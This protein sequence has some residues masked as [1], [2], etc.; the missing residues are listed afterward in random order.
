MD[1]ALDEKRRRARYIVGDI[2]LLIVSGLILLF[3]SADFS[4]AGANATNGEHKFYVAI[5][6][7]II[8]LTLLIL[9]STY[10]LKRGKYLVSLFFAGLP[11]FLIF[12]FSILSVLG[13]GF[14][15]LFFRV[16]H[17]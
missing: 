14:G 2:V 12:I 15:L 7:S 16:H 1:V 10:Y 8:F 17:G 5:S 11:F 3:I 6:I 13:M 9:G 4:V